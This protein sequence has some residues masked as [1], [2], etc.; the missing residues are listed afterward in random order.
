MFTNNTLIMFESSLLYL[1]W[2]RI[3]YANLDRLLGL[4]EGGK[5][6]LSSLKTMGG[7]GVEVAG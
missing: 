6:I 2:Q 3:I 5:A 4:G 7:G 1:G